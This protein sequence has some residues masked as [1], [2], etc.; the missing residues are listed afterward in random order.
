MFRFAKQTFF[1]GYK[2]EMG[3]YVTGPLSL[4]ITIGY[5]A[6]QEVGYHKNQYSCYLDFI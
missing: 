4:T 5:L 1:R 6:K 2:H 3:K